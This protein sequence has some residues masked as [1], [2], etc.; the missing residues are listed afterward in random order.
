MNSVGPNY[1]TG[2]QVPGTP[3]N[4]HLPDLSQPGYHGVGI[5]WNDATS[6]VPDWNAPGYPTSVVRDPAGSI[7]L[8]EETGGQQAGG[9]IWTCVCNGPQTSQN[10]GANGNLYQIDTTSI[11]QNAASMNGVNQGLLL[12]KAHGSQFNYLF[13]DGHVQALTIQQTVG[14]GTLAAPAGMWTVK[15]GD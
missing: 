13:C 5:Y 11:P 12:Y 4:Y 7:L 2:Y 6:Y 14:T 3:G 9:N 1:E 15:A 10:G 8:A